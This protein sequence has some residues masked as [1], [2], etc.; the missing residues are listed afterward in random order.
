[1]SFFDFNNDVKSI[2]S[3]HC[4]LQKSLFGEIVFDDYFQKIKTT[5]GRM[6][7]DDDF[8][9]ANIYKIYKDIND[10]LYI[11]VTCNT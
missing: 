2:I 7:D 11:G 6:N 9:I 8:N 1:M 4:N 3:K 10:V 5:P